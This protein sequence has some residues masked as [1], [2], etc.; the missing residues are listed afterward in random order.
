MKCK[1]CGEE[2]TLLLVSYACGCTDAAKKKPAAVPPKFPWLDRLDAI[3]NVRVPTPEAVISSIRDIGAVAPS[4]AYALLRALAHCEDSDEAR[5]A[6]ECLS[7]VNEHTDSISRIP[8]PIAVTSGWH[9][10]WMKN[11]CPDPP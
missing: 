8:C 11:C 3:F 4:T 5:L 10:A 2:K 7:R 1:T 9:N 6:Q